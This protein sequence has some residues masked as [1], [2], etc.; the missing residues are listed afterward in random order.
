MEAEVLEQLILPWWKL[1]LYMLA[2][3]VSGVAIRIAIKFDVNEWLK[4]RKEGRTKKDMEKAATTCGHLWTYYPHSPFSTCN[5]CLA[6]IP[7]STLAY[8]IRNLEPKPLSWA[9]SQ[10][11]S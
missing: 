4:Q 5:L 7:T 2:V 6:L 8:A 11:C 9:R 1:P 3:V 10:G